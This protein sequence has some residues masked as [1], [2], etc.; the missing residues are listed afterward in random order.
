MV[1]GQGFTNGAAEA[2]HNLMFFTD[3][4]CPRFSSTGADRIEVEGLYNADIYNAGRNPFFFKS[5]GCHQ[6]FMDHEAVGKESHIA[7]IA[8]NRR[9]IEVKGSV[10]RRNDRCRIAAKADVRRPL[11]IIDGP[12]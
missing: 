8:E 3:D 10:F 1:Q 11:D 9:L 4:G 2:A 7:T 12:A 5:L 6:G